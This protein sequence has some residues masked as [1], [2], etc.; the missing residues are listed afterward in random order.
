MERT[1]NPEGGH[2]TFVI[3]NGGFSW[4][5]I[6]IGLS[7]LVIPALA[8]AFPEKVTIPAS[9]DGLWFGGI[10]YAFGI[11][12]CVS[13][14]FWWDIWVL[15]RTTGTLV[16]QGRWGLL[17]KHRR[18]MLA[19]YDRVEIGLD[20]DSGPA[21]WLKGRRSERIAWAKSWKEIEASGQRIAEYLGFS[22]QTVHR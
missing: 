19:D 8:V 15:D 1:K 17:K 5:G 12:G 2:Q 13:S 21:I 4:W 16:M 3:R 22:I 11:F 10:V 18:R 9:Q 14:S 7:L 20:G 6:A